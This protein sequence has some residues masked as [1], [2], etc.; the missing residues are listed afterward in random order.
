MVLLATGSAVASG[1]NATL[2]SHPNLPPKFLAVDKKAQEFYVYSQQSPLQLVNRLRCTTGQRDG[3]KRVTGDL[4][5][6]EGV[7][8]V[9]RH[10][11]GGLDYALYGDQAFTLNFPNPVDRLKGKTGY[12][13]WIHGR[14]KPLVPRDTQGC[15]ALTSPDL[16]SVQGEITPGLP[17]AITNT[18]RVEDDAAI[19]PSEMDRTIDEL[20]GKV[21]GWATA[22][23]NGSDDFFA[24]YDAKRFSRAQRQPFEAFK[25]RK[26]RLFATYP[27]IRVIPYDI[28]VLPGPDYWVTYFR[29]YYR[30]P[31]VVSEGIKRLYWQ[32]D[33]KGRFRIVGRE[34]VRTPT[35]LDGV[36]L[37]ESR[38]DIAAMLE[39]WR[40]AWQKADLKGYAKAYA[41]SATQD[42]RRGRKDIVDHKADVWSRSKPKSV[43]FSDF[44]YAI[45]PEGVQVSFRQDYHARSGY[46]DSGRK[47]MILVPEA[48][49]WKIIREDWRAL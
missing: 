5:T 9:E 29:Q 26:K 48:G 14:G 33:D 18:V 12:G 49:S 4:R 20:V 16:H 45:V 6:P 44:S 30:T 42:E 39:K 2:D 7:Y 34:W 38:R 41:K 25:K 43:T 22:W 46:G 31:T 21:Q 40:G 15:V 10:L 19:S 1:W 47:T 8:F 28:R 11:T 36:Y 37:T 13:I 24:F 17:V 35:T 27:W 23:E 32:R 3:D